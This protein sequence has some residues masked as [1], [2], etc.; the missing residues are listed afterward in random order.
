MAND[1]PFI[2]NNQPDIQHPYDDKNARSFLV[3]VATS[4]FLNFSSFG[5]LRCGGAYDKLSLNSP[6]TLVLRGEKII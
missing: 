5:Y 6:K 2:S 1:V 3:A 4:L